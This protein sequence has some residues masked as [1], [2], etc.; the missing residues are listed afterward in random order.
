MFARHFSM[1]LN[2]FQN[3]DFSYFCS[4][5]FY[6]FEQKYWIFFEK[7]IQWNQ[8][9][10]RFYRF[11]ENC[12][13]FPEVVLIDQ[14]SDSG[15]SKSFGK[16]ERCTFTRYAVL[17][18]PRNFSDSTRLDEPPH[19]AEIHVHGPTYDQ[20]II[21]VYFISPSVTVFEIV[22]NCLFCKGIA[23]LRLITP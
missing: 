20:G 1:K 17:W 14:W 19:R 21:S 11:F 15:K 18:G 10:H 5:F 4:C 2:K 16:Y 22:L 23:L 12:S 13:Q 8:G 7:S 9:F 3:F 6:F